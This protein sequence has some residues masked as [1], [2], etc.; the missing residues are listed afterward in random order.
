[1]EQLHELAALLALDNLVQR[2]IDGLGKRSRSKKLARRIDLS[3]STSKDVLRRASDLFAGRGAA[4]IGTVVFFPRSLS[5][6]GIVSI[7]SGATSH[8]VRSSAVLVEPARSEPE[9][10]RRRHGG[11]GIRRRLATQ[12]D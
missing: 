7:P 4:T 6:R 8:A 12:K 3:K 2:G 9:I 11:T 1:M 5:H 10:S